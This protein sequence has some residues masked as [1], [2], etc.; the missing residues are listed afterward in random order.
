[1]K[2]VFAALAAI[3]LSAALA[4]EESEHSR[5]R[6]DSEK[7]SLSASLSAS[8]QKGSMRE[9]SALYANL[10]PR[11]SFSSPVGFE[12]SIASL[13][14]CRFDSARDAER[15]A[16]AAFGDPSLS[17]GY[18]FYAG[19]ARLSVSASYTAP[20]APWKPSGPEDTQL[21]AG[22][23]YHSLGAAIDASGILD[24]VLSRA[25]LSYQASFSK[26]RDEGGPSYRPLDLG[27]RLFFLEALNDGYS[28]SLAMDFG[29]S[30]GEWADGE[31][32]G[33]A[34]FSYGLSCSVSFRRES[35]A[36]SLGARLLASEPLAPAS[37]DAE[38]TWELRF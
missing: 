21:Y 20:L 8:L 37:L 34:S 27:L 26:P 23:G 19:D 32:L 6:L 24:P 3:V 28:L 36:L 9:P 15:P 10:A 31:A 7:S 11:L 30:L 4:A 1:M 35:F 33:D 13:F 16:L 22:S 5:L 25:S 12:C 14:L 29:F 2:Q 18:F 17:A 38:A